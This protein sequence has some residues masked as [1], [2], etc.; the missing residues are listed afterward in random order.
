MEYVQLY[1]VGQVTLASNQ[2]VAAALGEPAVVMCITWYE[3]LSGSVD[4]FDVPT[5]AA[6]CDITSVQFCEA[7]HPWVQDEAA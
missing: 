5:E 2:L 1:L 4:H 3:K 7:R 6:H